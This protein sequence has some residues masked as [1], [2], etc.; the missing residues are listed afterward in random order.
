MFFNNLRSPKLRNHE[1]ECIS[2]FYWSCPNGSYRHPSLAENWHPGHPGPRFHSF[3]F[4]FFHAFS[5][6][7]SLSCNMCILFSLVK[8]L[9]EQN[10]PVSVDET[11]SW[12]GTFG[13]LWWISCT[14][15]PPSRKWETLLNTVLYITILYCQTLLEDMM[16][17]LWDTLVP[18]GWFILSNLML[19]VAIYQNEMVILN[20][21]CDCS[22][23]R[24]L[25]SCWFSF[26]VSGHIR[27]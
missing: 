20:T 27:G 24:I 26:T 15:K 21:N 6:V 18:L 23:V 22:K 14:L 4:I 3:S 8:K 2:S 1:T 7:F 19:L 12:L 13:T 16:T 5:F 10:T 17:C 11:S 25:T 9:N